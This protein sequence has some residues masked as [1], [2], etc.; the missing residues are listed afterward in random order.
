MPLR[1]GISSTGPPAWHSGGGCQVNTPPRVMSEN[2]RP[3]SGYQRPASR[4]PKPPAISSRP[5]PDWPE[6]PGPPDGVRPDGAAPPERPGP[7]DGV[8]PDGAAPPERPGP[9][10]GVGPDG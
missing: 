5:L 9:P 3:V 6:R 7:P 2:T 10:D 4:R 1:W 8:G